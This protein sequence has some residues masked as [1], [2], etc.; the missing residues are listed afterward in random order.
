MPLLYHNTTVDVFDKM[1]V[2]YTSIN[3]F[4]TFWATHHRYMNDENEFQLGYHAL[5]MYLERIE[6]EEK[7][8]PQYQFYKVLNEHPE[9]LSK[10][11]INNMFKSSSER[12][13]S[14]GVAVQNYSYVISFSQQKDNIPMWY[15]YGDKGHGISLGFDENNLK[16]NIR[17]K[18]PQNELAQI[19]LNRCIYFDRKNGTPSNDIYLL[20]KEYYKNA[21]NKD[22]IKTLNMLYKTEEK[23]E[24]LDLC[25]GTLVSIFNNLIHLIGSTIKDSDWSFENEYRLNISN[26]RLDA[27]KYRQSNKLGYIPYLESYI[28]IDA[29]KEIIIGPT[30][31]Y[32][33]T[34][35]KIYSILNRYVINIRNI[36]IIPSK[37]FMRNT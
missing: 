11:L 20:V 23:I 6:E 37:V 14:S 15:I 8:P 26:Y 17:Y 21:A 13:E 2:N 35:K 18:D 29:L 5:M 25:P 34:T 19:K 1:L 30:E 9:N 33:S 3:P 31:D 36:D 24:G 27:I 4:L 7:I 10:L 12:I 32:L 22:V 28:G 16:K